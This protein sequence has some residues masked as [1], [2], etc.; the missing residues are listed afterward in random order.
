MARKASITGY[1][2]A[3]FVTSRP[4]PL[5]R[6]YTILYDGDDA[7]LNIED[8]RW[9]LFCP[10][11]GVL[12]SNTN[13]ARAIKL[14]RSPQEWCEQ[15]AVL[16]RAANEPPHPP[17]PMVRFVEKTPEDLDREMRF[18]AGKARHDPEKE[19]LFLKMYGVSPESYWD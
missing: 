13:K 18:W 11:H 15:C 5:T 3:G 9:S 1:D 12:A 17:K 8:G 4:N 10:D 16:A 6:G 14:L 19:A 2:E 7:G